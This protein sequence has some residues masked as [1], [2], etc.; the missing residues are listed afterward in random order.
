MLRSY[1]SKL[2]IA[3]I[4]QLIAIA[5]YFIMTSP[6]S[7]YSVAA[8]LPV[9]LSYG[10]GGFLLALVLYLFS[11]RYKSYRYASAIHRL[12]GLAQRGC[13]SPNGVYALCVLNAR[14]R[15]ALSQSKAANFSRFRHFTFIFLYLILDSI[16]QPPRVLYIYAPYIAAIKSASEIAPLGR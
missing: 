16:D 6:A 10:I 5:L 12:L 8:T 9:D 2:T 13:A 4:L 11:L 15:E 7:E 3:F 14:R 1:Q